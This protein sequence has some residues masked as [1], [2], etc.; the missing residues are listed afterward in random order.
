[1]WG[2]FYG[3]MSV[4]HHYYGRFEY[5]YEEARA[6]FIHPQTAIGT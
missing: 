6:Y 5:W 1:M 4:P 2:I 3:V